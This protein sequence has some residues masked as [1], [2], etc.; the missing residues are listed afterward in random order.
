M[1]WPQMW[2]SQAPPCFCLRLFLS[3]GTPSSSLLSSWQILLSL[4]VLSVNTTFS[5]NLYWLCQAGESTCLWSPST[6]THSYFKTYH[7]PLLPIDFP[8]PCVVLQTGMS[9]RHLPLLP[10]QHSAWP[11]VKRGPVKRGV[12][13]YFSRANWQ[14]PSSSFRA[15]TLLINS[16]LP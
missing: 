2:G 3:P 10:S 8:I 12:S 6:P 11:S 15:L 9:L 1:N 13:A 5:L 14:W 7:T 4:T 16:A